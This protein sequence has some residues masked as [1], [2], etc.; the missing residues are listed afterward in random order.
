VFV[1]EFGADIATPKFDT[2]NPLHLPEDLL[3]WNSLAT[4]IVYPKLAHR[5]TKNPI[6]YGQTDNGEKRSERG[7][8]PLMTEGFS[9]IF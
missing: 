7:V 5:T 2:E 6:T 3:I 9:L 1:L 8:L 4:L